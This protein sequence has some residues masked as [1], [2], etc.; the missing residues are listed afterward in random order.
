[1]VAPGTARFT[2]MKMSAPQGDRSSES[3]RGCAVSACAS[4]IRAMSLTTFRR[5]FKGTWKRQAT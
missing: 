2:S 1:M 4:W 5:M 3:M